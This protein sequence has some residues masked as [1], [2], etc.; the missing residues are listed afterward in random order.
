MRLTFFAK[1]GGIREAIVRINVSVAAGAAGGAATEIIDPDLGNIDGMSPL[2]SSVILLAK[3]CYSS[4][5][6]KHKI[7]EAFKEK[8]VHDGQADYKT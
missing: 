5:G 4:D 2:P 3:L 1:S 7:K 8:G 6:L